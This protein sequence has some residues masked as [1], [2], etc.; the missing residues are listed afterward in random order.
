MRCVRW[1]LCS[2]QS[3]AFRNLFC[4]W[5][6]FLV[7]FDEGHS[8]P[9]VF[10]FGLNSSGCLGTGDSLSTIVP[11][12]LDFLRGK[13][14]ASLS[15][16]SGP[17]VLLA[18]EGRGPN[19]PSYKCP[20]ITHHLYLLPVRPCAQHVPTNVCS[21]QTDSCLPGATTATV[22]WGMGPPTR[23]CR[24]CRSPSTH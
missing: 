9:Q 15:Y 8:F 23:D 1:T 11:K 6:W 7:S 5:H 16:G 13:K 2:S 20:Q 12:K 21:L 14:V 17:H 19:H 18:T 24:R 22:S 10:V 4:S 3:E